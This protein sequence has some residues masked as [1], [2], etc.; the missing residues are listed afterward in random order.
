MFKLF[1]Y[2]S[3]LVN[4]L[5]RC[6]LSCKSWCLW[7]CVTMYPSPATIYLAFSKLIF[8]FFGNIKVLSF[9]LLLMPFV[10]CRNFLWNELYDFEIGS[11]MT[12]SF[13]F[14]CHIGCQN[15]IADPPFLDMSIRRIWRMHVQRFSSVFYF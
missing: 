15:F 6:K 3:Y 7:Q 2:L 8:T 10:A 5:L 11:M 12:I 14:S 1:L 4:S 13:R 9:K